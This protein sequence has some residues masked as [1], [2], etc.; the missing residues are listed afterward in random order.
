MSRKG[1]NIFK[2]KDGRWEARYIHHYENGKAKYRYVYGATYAEAKARKT[3]EQTMRSSARRVPREQGGTFQELADLWLMDI[4]P[5]IKESTYTRYHRTVEK[6]LIPRIGGQTFAR[7]DQQYLNNL[8]DELLNRGGMCG[9]PLSAKTVADILSVL[10]SIMRF[11]MKYGYPAPNIDALHYPLRSPRLVGIMSEEHRVRIEQLVMESSDLTGLGILVALFTGVR[12][13]EL[14][15]LRWAD[16][17]FQD[18]VLYVRRTVER[19]ADLNP[20]SVQKTKVVVSAP[21]TNS[22]LRVIPIPEFLIQFLLKCRREPEHYL[23]T[24]TTDHTEPHQYYIRYRKFL[25]RNN[26]TDYNFHTLR[27][28]FATRC[29]EAGFDPKTLAEILGHANV[30]TTLS[31]YVHPTMQQKKTQMERLTPSYLA[32]CPE[33]FL[34]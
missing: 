5:V 28:T 34:R 16:I 19:I 31:A 3:K 24:G 21:K 13:G 22:S 1:E 10:K 14:C 17:N 26:I 32:P 27:H 6:Y 11:A 12:I 20:E 18:T 30:T 29:V 33:P 9:R 25:R 8:P 23:L 2:R 15:G 4:K 7:M